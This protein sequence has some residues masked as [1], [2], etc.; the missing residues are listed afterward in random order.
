MSYG[1]WR[2]NCNPNLLYRLWKNKGKKE[3]FNLYKFGRTFV[4]YSTPAGDF[5]MIKSELLTINEV[6]DYMEQIK[7][8]NKHG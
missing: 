7:K 5:T 2:D 6:N 3:T 4:T 1:D 8:G